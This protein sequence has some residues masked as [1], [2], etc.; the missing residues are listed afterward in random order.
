VRPAFGSESDALNDAVRLGIINYGEK[1]TQMQSTGRLFVEQVASS[2]KTPLMGVLLEGARETGK[3]ALAAMLAKESGY[4]FIKVS[5]PLVKPRCRHPARS[6]SA[7]RQWF[8]GSVPD[9]HG[10]YAAGVPGGA[11]V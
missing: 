4:P 8:G 6:A 9:D 7:D 1:F 3:T 10:R 5:H 11:E 2:D